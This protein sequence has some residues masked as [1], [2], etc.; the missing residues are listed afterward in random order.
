MKLNPSQFVRMFALIEG[1]R[2]MQEK[3]DEKKKTNPKIVHPLDDHT[4]ILDERTGKMVKRQS[5]AIR[6]LQ[7]FVEEKGTQL[8]ARFDDVNFADETERDIPAGRR[9]CG[10]GC[11]NEFAVTVSFEE[12]LRQVADGIYNI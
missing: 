6:G 8:G 4:K 7:E 12:E 1:L 9:I 11:G 5:L 3:T 10:D 2:M